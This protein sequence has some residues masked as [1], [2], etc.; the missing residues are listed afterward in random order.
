M[1][2]ISSTVT[3][4]LVGV[5]VVLIKVI[6]W[7]MKRSSEA[8]KPKLAKS[9]NGF[10]EVLARIDTKLDGTLAALTEM[11]QERGQFLEFMAASTAAYDRIA[12]RID[13]RLGDMVVAIERLNNNINNLE[14]SIKN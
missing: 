8:N 7:F 14:R 5:I 2:L 1:E 9:Y 3:A 12:D 4:A 11:R 10:G 6:E 13:D